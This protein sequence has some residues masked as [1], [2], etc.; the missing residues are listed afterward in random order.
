MKM[1]WLLVAVFTGAR[2]VA[3]GETVPCTASLEIL[4]WHEICR[5]CVSRCRIRG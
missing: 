2:R 1:M 4:D 3:V 5:N